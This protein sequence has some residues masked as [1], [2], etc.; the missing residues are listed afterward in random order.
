MTNLDSIL[1][2]RDITLPAKVCL[3]KVMVFSIG[4]VWMWELDSKESWVLKNWYFW[5]VVWEKT[6]ESPLDCKEIQTVHPRGNQS[7]IFIGR[8]ELKL[9]LQ[10]FGHLM[11][12]TDSLEKSLMLGKIESRRRRI[13]QRWDVWMASPTQW[14]WVWVGS[15]SWWLTRGK[16]SGE[17]QEIDGQGSL[18]CCSPCG[19]KE[20]DMTERLNWTELE[21]YRSV[22]I[23]IRYNVV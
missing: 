14:T 21:T 6:L 23:C 19:R 11:R 22:N 18:V 13:Q 8:T 7:W 5:T 2:S 9:K 4:H 20:L 3:V 16:G 17:G 12:R 1:K 10:Y 15:E